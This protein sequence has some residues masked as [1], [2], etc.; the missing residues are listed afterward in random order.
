MP[1][2]WISYGLG[3][4]EGTWTEGFCGNTGGD[5]TSQNTAILTLIVPEHGFDGGPADLELLQVVNSS[6]LEGPSALIIVSKVESGEVLP[7]GRSSKGV[8]KGAAYVFRRS[9]NTPG[10]E[11]LEEKK[12]VLA[13]GKGTDRFGQTVIVAQKGSNRIGRF[14]E[15]DFL[16]PIIMG[17][18]LNQY[19]ESNC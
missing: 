5:E 13:D 1:E 14:G 19:S 15:I 7:S 16:K 4:D 12:L 9:L 17:S 8:R 2:L 6:S 11:W 3:E 18:M 10:S